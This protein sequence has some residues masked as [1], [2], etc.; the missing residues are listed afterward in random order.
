MV[1]HLVAGS[2]ILECAFLATRAER[3]G[4]IIYSNRVEVDR[5]GDFREDTDWL[6][7]GRCSATSLIVCA[8]MVGA[9]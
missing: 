7:S 9:S 5:Y 3:L 8:N 2:T 1:K 4:R 6:M